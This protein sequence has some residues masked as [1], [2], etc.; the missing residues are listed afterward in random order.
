MP[1]FAL[2]SAPANHAS[3]LLD[4]LVLYA[5]YFAAKLLI[6]RHLGGESFTNVS[7]EL[8]AELSHVRPVVTALQNHI[9]ELP[10]LLD[11]RTRIVHH[12]MSKLWSDFNYLLPLETKI[13]YNKNLF[14]PVLVKYI[15]DGRPLSRV[16]KSL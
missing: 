13:I 5:E 9:V 12:R 16:L 10:S 15:V 6:L 3:R 2:E 1:L 11:R 4:L 14:T 8:D 7:V